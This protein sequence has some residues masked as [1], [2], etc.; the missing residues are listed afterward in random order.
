MRQEEGLLVLT[1]IISSLEY[2]LESEVNTG[3]SS[4]LF[5]TSLS[6]IPPLQSPSYIDFL[7]FHNTMS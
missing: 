5:Y 1:E 3:S 7:L 2:E 4:L 6:S